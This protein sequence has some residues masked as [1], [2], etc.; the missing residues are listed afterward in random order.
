MTKYNVFYLH[1]PYHNADTDLKVIK[2]WSNALGKERIL[3][4]QTS[5]ACVD[6]MLGAIALTA[7]VRTL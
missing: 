4:M 6:V 1:K 5:K 7:G 2:Q 3:P